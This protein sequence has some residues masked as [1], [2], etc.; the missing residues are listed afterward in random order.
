MKQT[1]EI[2][3]ADQVG[4]RVRS[5]RKE[6]GLRQE[7]LAKQLNRNIN[8]VSAIENGKYLATFAQAVTLSYAL[9]CSLDWLAGVKKKTEK[10]G[11]PFASLPMMQR[12]VMNELNALSWHDQKEV[13]LFVRY[14]AYKRK[15]G[16][17]YAE[18]EDE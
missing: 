2:K 16:T 8:T 1:D 12:R 7:E 10:P 4:A 9:D 11:D 17:E 6:L 3:F 15:G 18:S 14:M 5:R 13:L